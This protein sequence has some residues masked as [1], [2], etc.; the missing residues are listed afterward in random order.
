MTSPSTRALLEAAKAA[1]TLL[2]TEEEKRGPHIQNAVYVIQT[3]A[4]K[5]REM[6][7]AAEKREAI[8]VN[9]RAA[10][11]DCE[12]EEIQA[13]KNLEQAKENFKRMQAMPDFDAE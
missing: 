2:P 7:N 9:L 11:R 8:A 13:A 4:S 3:E 1:A 6:A 12:A 10:I 5:L